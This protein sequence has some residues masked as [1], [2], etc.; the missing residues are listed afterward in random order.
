MFVQD[1]ASRRFPGL[2][3]ARVGGRDLWL[4]LKPPAAWAL[5][6]C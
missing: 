1:E 5:E 3:A 2:G 4:G 6:A